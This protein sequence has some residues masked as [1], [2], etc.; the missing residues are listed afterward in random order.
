MSQTI[1]ESTSL[2]KTDVQSND[3]TEGFQDRVTVY[4]PTI[5][6]PVIEL[7]DK[8]QRAIQK[9]LSDNYQPEVIPKGQVAQHVEQLTNITKQIKSIAT[10]GVLLHGERIQQAQKLLSN[11]GDG[12]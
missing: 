11:Y 7:T 9:I 12:A 10:Q 6:I 3:F 2:C 1:Q 5:A 4:A 8:E